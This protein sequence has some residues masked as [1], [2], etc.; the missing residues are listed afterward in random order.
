VT[1]RVNKGKKVDV[2]TWVDG[3]MDRR[4]LTCSFLLF[5][6]SV[7]VPAATGESFED[8]RTFN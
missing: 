7:Y 6:T 5:S 4:Q 8:K 3:W 2:I 1:K